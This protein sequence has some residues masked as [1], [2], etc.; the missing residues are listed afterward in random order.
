MDGGQTGNRELAG[1]RTGESSVHVALG[2][3]AGAHCDQV[4]RDVKNVGYYLSRR[5][6]VP[7]ALG[8]GT[9]GHHHLA[10]NFEL[11]VRAL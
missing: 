7:L 3:E 2:V 8:T 5:G 6:L 9:D 1:V 11:T 10:I 4:G